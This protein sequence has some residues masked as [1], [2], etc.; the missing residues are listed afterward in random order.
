MPEPSPDADHRFEPFDRQQR[1]RAR[2]RAAA[3][4]D[5]FAF[6]K[7]TV[8]EDIADRAAAFERDWARCLDLGAHDGRLGQMIGAVEVIAADAGEGFAR[9]VS[10]VVCDEDRLPFADASFDLIVSAL[11]LHGVNDLPGALVQ[12]RRALTPGG[13]FIAAIIGGQTAGEIRQALLTADIERTGGAVPRTLPMVDPAEAPGLMQRA[14]FSEPVVDIYRY[15]IG[16]RDPLRMLR[17]V[18]GMGE[19][20][21][22]SARSRAPV[23]RAGLSGWLAQLQPLAEEGRMPVP[24]EVLTL[25]GTAPGKPAEE[26][27]A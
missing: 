2:D 3:A 4:Y 14:G 7:Q 19:S 12:A 21:Y 6:L 20:N 13:I 9:Q 8:A 27:P 1:R 23:S 18:R 26:G 5:E 17:D 10:G 24:V 22:L 25:T 16:Y 15:D 11:S